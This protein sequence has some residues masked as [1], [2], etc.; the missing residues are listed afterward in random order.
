[1]RNRQA[2]K[3]SGDDSKTIFISIHADSLHRSLRGA[4]V[5]IPAT[6]LTKG[7]Y[8]KTAKVY[9]SRREVKEQPR[10]NFSWK[11]RTRSEGLSRQ[12]AEQLLRQFRRQ[13][14][15]VHREK[16]I[17]DRIILCRRCRAYVP[18][19]VRRNAVPTKVL[20]EICNLNNPQDR[21]LVRTRAY[22]Q[23]VAVAIVD[24][25]LA[26]Y[27]QPALPSPPPRIA[28]GGEG[29]AAAASARDR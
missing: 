11:E 29:A 20:I 22:R 1:M 13:G 28:S 7:S 6:S 27:G 14:L 5:Y 24:S 2:V 21:Q 25:I 12:F 8:G 23:K 17:R 19:V 26:Y 4:M 10:I 9:T 15:A 18:A 16:P 3:R